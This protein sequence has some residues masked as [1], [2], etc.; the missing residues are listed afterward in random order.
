M[1]QRQLDIILPVYHEEENIEEVINSIQK[2][3]RT[4]YRVTL[5]FQDRYDPTRQVIKKLQKKLKNINVIF[6]KDGKGLV[7]ALKEGFKETKFAIIVIMMADLSDNAKDIDKM[8]TKINQ[9]YD[10]VCASR[11][12]INGRRIGGPKMKG[13]LSHIACRSLAI[14]TGLPTNDATNAFK[15]FRR[16]LLGKI[17]IESKKGF[18]MPLELT[19]KAFNSGL[20]ITEIPTIWK[21][22][23]RGRSKFSLIQNTPLYLRWYFYCIK[24][25][26][27][28]G[29]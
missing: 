26:I 29:D 22:R 27:K 19:V 28:I 14:L 1:I 5:V 10:L 25:S 20:K 24:N 13:L 2:Y 15:C 3:V 4:P 11:Y 12:S 23:K 18:E 17:S 6:T 8:V 7:K 9:G 16:S 21:D